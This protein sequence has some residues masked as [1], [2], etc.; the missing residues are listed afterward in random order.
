MHANKS[1][2]SLC[3][4]PVLRIYMIQRFPPIHAFAPHLYHSHLK[5][6]GRPVNV[7]WNPVRKLFHFAVCLTTKQLPFCHNAMT[8]S[9]LHKR[10]IKICWY[11]LKNPSAIHPV[12]KN[13]SRTTAR[14]VL[15]SL[16]YNL[17]QMTATKTINNCQGVVVYGHL[18]KW[19]RESDDLVWGAKKSCNFFHMTMIPFTTENPLRLRRLS[20]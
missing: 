4:L 11:L 14:S 18:F 15:F 16:N 17:L 3:T 7:S 6:S 8:V 20:V 2:R 5:K 19:N 13:R 9:L 12:I 1:K 10:G